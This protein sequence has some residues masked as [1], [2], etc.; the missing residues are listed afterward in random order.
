[1]EDHQELSRRSGSGIIRFN[2]KK[3]FVIFSGKA[4][5]AYALYDLEDT[6]SNNDKT[7]VSPSISGGHYCLSFWFYKSSSS[8]I[9]NVLLM[10]SM[11]TILLWNATGSVSKQWT[12]TTIEV[13]SSDSFQVF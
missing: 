8:S 10:S 3:G 13:Q 6:R 7:M 5:D 1:M 2:M 11:S 4:G 9:L 12:H